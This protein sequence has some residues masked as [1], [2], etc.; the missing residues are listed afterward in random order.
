MTVFQY[1]VIRLEK[2][3]QGEREMHRELSLEYY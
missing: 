1:E 2:T 3:N